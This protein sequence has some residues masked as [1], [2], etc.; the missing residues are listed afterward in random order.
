MWEQPSKNPRYSW[1]F[2]PAWEF[3]Q[4]LLKFSSGYECKKNLFYFFHKIIIFQHNKKKDDIKSTVYRYFFYKTVNSHNLE[5]VNHNTHIIFNFIAL[6][7]HL[8]TNQNTCVTQNIIYIYIYKSYLKYIF[9]STHVM[10]I[11]YNSWLILTSGTTF[12]VMCISFVRKI[13]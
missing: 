8:L 12:N 5:T 11:D 3:S 4:K 6:W 13:R 1:G 9:L 2:S 7:K 10:I